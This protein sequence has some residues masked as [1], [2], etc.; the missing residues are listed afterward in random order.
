MNS[1][2][3]CR[4]MSKYLDQYAYFY[5]SNYFLTMS[6]HKLG[7]IVWGLLFIGLFICFVK[8]SIFIMWTN[9]YIAWFIASNKLMS[10]PILLYVLSMAGDMTVDFICYLIPS[11][12]HPPTNPEFLY[13]FCRDHGVSFLFM[14]GKWNSPVIT[15]HVDV[16]IDIWSFV[17]LGN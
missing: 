1:V 10:G 13:E 12:F 6:V 4:L 2:I 8:Y 11:S 16:V 15:T 5:H 9:I 14:G 17:H 7:K 3:I